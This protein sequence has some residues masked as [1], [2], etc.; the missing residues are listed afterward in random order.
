MNQSCL[1]VWEKNLEP[2]LRSA[3][4]NIFDRCAT[5]EGW[6]GG[7]FGEDDEF[8]S[9]FEHV[10]SFGMLKRFFIGWIWASCLRWSQA[11]PV[12]VA[13]IGIIGIHIWRSRTWR[14]CE[15]CLL[16]VF[17][18]SPYFWH[19][20]HHESREK[21]LEMCQMWYSFRLNMNIQSMTN[22]GSLGL[23]FSQVLIWTRNRFVASW[24]VIMY[25]YLHYLL[26]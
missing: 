7:E 17:Q 23:T 22:L 21:N 4:G 9:T 3:G 1:Q 10:G 20:N 26:W 24:L 13:A 15:R 12:W 19:V 16:E 14:G 8:F 18:C 2:F 5:F 25:T 6:E 11:F